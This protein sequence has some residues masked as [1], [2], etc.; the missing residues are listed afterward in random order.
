M[1]RGLLLV[2]A[3]ALVAIGTCVL[4][5]GS[6]SAAVAANVKNVDER[7][8]IPYQQLAS[9]DWVNYY[10]GPTCSVTLP[11]VPA[12]KRLVMTNVNGE[13]IVY[14]YAGPQ[15]GKP[16]IWVSVPGTMNQV[17]IPIDFGQ[18]VENPYSPTALDFPVNAQV[19]LFVEAGQS[20]KVSFQ[21]FGPNAASNSV[22]PLVLITGYLVDLS[23]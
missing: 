2:L 10:G 3:C 8:R 12:N 4:L 19:L 22:N 18:A 15:D 11:A 6:A 9:C 7:G 20:L 21:V 16:G 1:K 17:R 13:F 5:P 14:Y 23:M